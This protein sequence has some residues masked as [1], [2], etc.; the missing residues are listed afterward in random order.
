MKPVLH[1]LTL[2]LALVFAAQA[3]DGFTAFSKLSDF[4]TEGAWK[5]EAD[6]SIGLYPRE[7]EKGWSRY[8]SYLWLKKPYKDFILDLEFKL[9][10]KGNSGIYFRCKDKVDP[11]AR[12]IEL[13]IL[14]SHNKKGKLGHHDGG[15]IIRTSG[16]SKNMNKPAGEWN[17]VIV[18]CKGTHLQVEMNGEKIQDLQL[19]Q[20]AVKDRPLEGWIG[21]QDHGQPL[22]F[23]N[24]KIKE[25]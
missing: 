4:D 9:P 19:D 11:T 8:G 1:M 16:P 20:S 15:G 17:R 14:D 7:G 13:Q 24:I 23:R 6:G 21:L 10:P 12:G 22:W 18:N 3:K 25:Q 2:S 5:M